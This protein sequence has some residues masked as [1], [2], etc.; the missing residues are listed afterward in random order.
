M[1]K[2]NKPELLS[3]GVENTFEGVFDCGATTYKT[4]K[5]EHYCH[6]DNLWHR[7]NCTSL[8]QGHFQS[9]S[10]CPTGGNHEWAGQAHKSNCCCGTKD[11]AP[12]QS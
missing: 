4:A 6:R 12:G 8:Q 5:N 10:N 11:I 3:L 1:K 9:G 2:W 7:N